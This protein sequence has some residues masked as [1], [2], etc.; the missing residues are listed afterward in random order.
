MTDSLAALLRDTVG[1]TDSGKTAR[2]RTDDV[3]ASTLAL[4]DVTIEDEL[5]NLRRLSRTSSSHAGGHV[6]LFDV[7]DEVL[8]LGVDGQR[9][10]VLRIWS[11]L[12]FSR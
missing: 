10:A 9:C 6:V 11:S 1:D 4:V 5:R 12:A 2:L 3:A 7:L 8:R